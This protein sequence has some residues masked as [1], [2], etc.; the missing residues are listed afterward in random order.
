MNFE[1][2]SEF[3]KNRKLTISDEQSK[4]ENKSKSK[5]TIDNNLLE[6]INLIKVKVDGC[7]G[8]AGQKCDYLILIFQKT[9][10]TELS[11]LEILKQQPLIEIYI[12]LKGRNV[13]DAFKQFDNTIKK[14]SREHKKLPKLCYIICS[15]CAIPGQEIENKKRHFKKQYNASLKIESSGSSGVQLSKICD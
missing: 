4:G 7:L 8:F 12:E 10:A 6:S 1:P 14:I 9:K 2:C 15:R 5:F 11:L 13:S 3:C